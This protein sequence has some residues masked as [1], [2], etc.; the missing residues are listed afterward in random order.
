MVVAR[1]W[2]QL[3]GRLGAIVNARS[4]AERLGLEF[5]FVWP[6]GI[7]LE[8]DDPEQIFS[9]AFLDAFEIRPS[10]LNGRPFVKHWEILEGTDSD[11]RS[12]LTTADSEVFVE[13]HEIF[14]VVR[15]AIESIPAARDRFRRCFDEI[16][17]SDDVRRLIDWCSAWPLGAD[18]AAIHVRAGD[19]VDGRWRHVLCH[20]KYVPTPFIYEAIERLSEGA[21]KQVLVLSD[22]APYLA[23]L[24]ERF[25]TVITAAETVPGYGSLTSMQQALADILMLSR[26]EP[27]VGP[28]SSAFSRLAA[29]LGPGSL[30]R[31]DRLVAPGQERNV[32]RSG[33][34]VR[35]KGVAKP[36]FSDALTARDICWYLDV[37]GDTLTLRE[38]VELARRAFE[39]DPEF[40][41]A[42]TRFA[43]VGSLAGDS[44]AARETS[45]RTIRIAE[46][47][48]RH[49]DPLMESLA[50]EVASNCFAA[51]RRPLDR[52]LPLW[53]QNRD[54]R[55]E[56]RYMQLLLEEIKQSF[57]R[58]LELHPFWSARQE[59][60][61]SL[62]SLI[63]MA[64][65]LSDET[66][67]VR[68]R[69]A[70]SLAAAAYDDVDMREVRPDGLEQHRALAMFDPLTRDL[71]RMA[72]H[73][74]DAL[75]RAGVA[76]DP[77]RLAVARLA[78]AGR[79]DG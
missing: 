3:G 36:T 17:W 6:R 11:A 46:A 47:A 19:I 30:V 44:R 77:P 76:V 7:D 26:C 78:G 52:R 4:I 32:L 2:D 51:I 56:R 64:E 12:A 72:L 62:G 22:N 55:G 63:A 71:D 57:D 5:R 61:E 35:R 20:E 43:R 70:R 60:L 8:L 31:A 50:T 67:S 34:A 23:W 1:R 37:F 68:K 53:L 73:L 9:P 74:Y 48:E 79:D 65:H 13:V 42:L 41:G 75:Q 59:T 25:P 16:D 66:L 40:T 27:V 33:I 69:A 45:A 21:T 29:N 38:Q 39:L 49:D 28:P 10:E 14:D 54:G 58:C 15:F 18:I 24:A